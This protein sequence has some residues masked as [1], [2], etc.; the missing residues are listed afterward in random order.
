M[1]HDTT[2]INDDFINNNIQNLNFVVFDSFIE[3]CKR[4]HIVSF[5]RENWAKRKCT[6]LYYLKK[7]HCYHIFVI[8]VNER[9]IKITI[10]YK[11]VKI[12]IKP[13]VGRTSKEKKTML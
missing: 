2:L 5:N 11:N 1:T 3:C 12:G 6:C 8:A 9:L 13:K 4:V 10:K 7:Y